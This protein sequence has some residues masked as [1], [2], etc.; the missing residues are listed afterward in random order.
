MND[1]S[2]FFIVGNKCDLV[3]KKAID[4]KTAN[5]FADKLGIPFL[6]TS[7]KN[8]TNVEKAFLAVTAEIKSTIFDLP[9]VFDSIDP[10]VAGRIH[11]M[12]SNH[13]K[14]DDESTNHLVNSWTKQMDNI[15]SELEE[16]EL[17]TQKEEVM[18]F[19]HISSIRKFWERFLAICFV[20]TCIL[21]CVAMVYIPLWFMCMLTGTNGLTSEMCN[22]PFYYPPLLP[23]PFRY[24]NG[25]V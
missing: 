14:K 13:D 22:I 2:Y 11:Q 5:D 3:S 6:E 4:F 9:A 16:A 15:D 7:A 20:I 23:R 19:K 17:Q 24:Q 25:T 1:L 21:G 10:S 8:G 12:V 18:R